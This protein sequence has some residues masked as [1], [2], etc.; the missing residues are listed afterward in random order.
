MPHNLLQDTGTG[1]D[2]LITGGKIV[3]MDPERRVIDQGDVVIAGNRIKA[4][5]SA[6]ERPPEIK[7]QKII[8][9]DGKVLIPGLINA[10]SH[11]AMTLFRGF[12]EDLVLHKWLER[13]WKYELT[14]LNADS[15]RA[16]SKL[17][18]AEMI[19]SGV[20]CVHDMYWHYMA[21]IDL[22]EEVGFRLLN[23]TP[24][25][26]IG[27]PDVNE[28]IQT[29]HNVFEHIKNYR[30]VYPIVQAHSTYTTT[31]AMM[32]QVYEFIHTYNIPFT[33]HAAENQAEVDDVVEKFGKT[34][35][36][37]LYEYNL[38]DKGTV[39]A[40]CVKLQDHEIALLSETRANVAHCPQSNLKLGSGIARIADMIA[41]GVN[42]CI[43]TD[44]AASN[45]D[46]DLL[47]E[48]RTAALLQKGYNENP[49]LLTT[50]Q[51]MEMATINGARAYGLD[52]DLGSLEPGK[53]ADIVIIDFDKSHLTPCHDVYAHLVYAV[54]KADVDTVL[55]DGKIHLDNGNLVT[56]D[57]QAII[58]EARII[59]ESFA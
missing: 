37:L 7:A 46:M 56:L 44:G 11:I 52:K 25:T 58:A 45:N 21:T 31:P 50:M 39:L 20:T 4:I 24:F 28:M 42:V 12:V 29:A 55:I 35:V 15:V 1:C 57:E 49:E 41:A 8:H 27:D 33:T 40:H 9:A 22:A 32:R 23:G 36:E 53:C 30:F 10:H 16:G 59:G 19:R 51:A 47:S 2:I 43:G 6:G 26:A 3:T 13:V 38:L 48:I 34:P 18:I 17:A 5:Y 54:N 14:T